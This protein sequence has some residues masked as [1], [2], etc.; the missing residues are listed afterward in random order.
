MPVQL[1]LR[2][3][4]AAPPAA[5][6]WAAAERVARAALSGYV[7]QSVGTATFYHA[8]YVLPKWAFTLKQDREDRRAHLLPLPGSWGA[9]GTFAAGGAGRADPRHQLRVALARLAAEGR[10]AGD[11]GL[12]RDLLSRAG[13]DR[14]PQPRPTSA[15]DQSAEAV[16]PVASRADEAS[17]RYRSAIGRSGRG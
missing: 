12:S 9:A 13:S 6:A 2:R 3:R 4:A 1:H 7:E 10:G 11:A 16:A 17:S 8:D 5:D 14:P 15:A